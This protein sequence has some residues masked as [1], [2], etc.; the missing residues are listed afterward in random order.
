MRFRGAYTRMSFHCNVSL[1]LII[2]DTLEIVDIDRIFVLNSKVLE[3]TNHVTIAEVFD[4]SLSILWPERI[5]R[6]NVL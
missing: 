6:Y 1:S 4:K 2:I 5:I 3:K